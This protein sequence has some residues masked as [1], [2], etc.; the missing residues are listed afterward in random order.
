[1]PGEQGDHA[2]E[3]IL[4]DQR[5]AR[6]GDHALPLRPLLVGDARVADDGVGQV[7][8]ALLG[9]QADLE[10]ADGDAPVRAV[11]VRVL[12]RAGPQHQH[13]LRR[14]QRPDAGESRVQVC[15]QSLGATL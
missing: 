3:P 5:I 7:R 11:Q 2:D 1:M 15:D 14:I 8:R 12:S 6:E 4:H 13:V 9:D 10:P